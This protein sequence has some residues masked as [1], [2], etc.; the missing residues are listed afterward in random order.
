MTDGATYKP[1]GLE[2][3][4]LLLNNISQYIKNVEPY[5]IGGPGSSQIGVQESIIDLYREGLILVDNNP[6]NITSPQANLNLI[7]SWSS[8]QASKSNQS[9][10]GNCKVSLDTWALN[11]TN[12]SSNPFNQAYPADY[13][14]GS[15]SCLGIFS[16]DAGTIGNRYSDSKFASC[17]QVNG[18][19]IAQILINQYNGL[20]KH[21]DDV[22]R[23]FRY[24]KEYYTDNLNGTYQDLLQSGG[25]LT[26]PIQSLNSTF[27]D[28]LD[29]VSGSRNGIINN[30]NCAFF[31]QRLLSANSYLCDAGSDLR[32]SFAALVVSL[33]FGAIGCI[34]MYLYLRKLEAGFRFIDDEDLKESKLSRITPIQ[35]IAP[36]TEEFKSD[37][38]RGTFSDIENPSLKCLV[39]TERD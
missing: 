15:Q 24:L 23:K 9:L 31:R 26:E 18:Q 29:Y 13:Q 30:A 20:N 14:F 39:R 37:G 10:L 3:T 6:D 17:N 36:R 38:E 21:F 19:T 1:A 12:C 11:T 8:Y 32:K 7:N 35:S 16:L 27:G 5:T 4:T 28:Y 34:F 25:T 22:K 33:V 2:S